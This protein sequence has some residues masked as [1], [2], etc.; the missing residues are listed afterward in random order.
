M[1]NHD[2]LQYAPNFYFFNVSHSQLLFARTTINN[3][4][5]RMNIGKFFPNAIQ[6]ME[7]SYVNAF[8]STL[9]GCNISVVA[10]ISEKGDKSG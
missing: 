7:T 8:L 9:P 1:S 5:K 4:L 10:V 2:L 6:V 3:F